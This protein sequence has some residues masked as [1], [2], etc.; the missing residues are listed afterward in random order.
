MIDSL[1]VE[2]CQQIT[3]RNKEFFKTPDLAK[4]NL[5]IY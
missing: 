3:H 1:L 5:S 2:G 4:K